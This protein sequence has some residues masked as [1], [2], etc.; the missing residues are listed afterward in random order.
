MPARSTARRWWWRAAGSRSRSSARPISRCASPGS[1]ASPWRRPGPAWCRCASKGPS[2]TSVRPCAASP[3]TRD[4]LRRAGVSRER[5][6][7]APRPVGPGRAPGVQ[8]LAA[9]RV[10]RDR[11]AAGGGCG[12]ARA[13]GARAG[14]GLCGAAGRAPSA[15][16]RSGLGR[17]LRPAAAAARGEQGGARGAGAAPAPWRLR[18]S[19]ERGLCQGRGDRGRRGDER[20]VL[21]HARLPARARAPLHRG[22]RRRHRLARRLQL[23]VGLGLGLRGRSVRLSARSSLRRWRRRRA[24]SREKRRRE[25]VPAGCLAP[26]FSGQAANPARPP[27]PL[28]RD[29]RPAHRRA[30]ARAVRTLERGQVLARETAARGRGG[31][32]R[33]HPRPGSPAGK[34][35][36]RLALGAS[37]S[38]PRDR[39]AGGAGGAR[40][41]ARGASLLRV[42]R[43][44]RPPLRAARPACGCG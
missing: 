34:R 23:P 13:R 15:A 38:H 2:W 19:T 10:H 40:H 7:H 33:L 42:Q 25:P 9:G 5:A 12:A 24:R 4:E 43:D 3:S 27:G 37:R 30:C 1:S 16:F 41:L 21:P 18:P 35:R 26:G 20:A 32:S 31:G 14:A 44:S 28:P 6:L 11:S 8:L 39:C 29:A 17:A 36:P 22:G